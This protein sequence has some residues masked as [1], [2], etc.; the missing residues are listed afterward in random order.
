[1]FTS[2]PSIH[3]WVLPTPLTSTTG[4]EKSIDKYKYGSLYYTEYTLS[5]AV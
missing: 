5:D 2:H 3:L 4:R 1:M